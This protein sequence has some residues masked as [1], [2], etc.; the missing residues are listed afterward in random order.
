MGM[1]KSAV[2]N[3]VR[4][5]SIALASLVNEFVSFPKDNPG[6][7]CPGQAQLFSFGEYAQYHWSNR[8]HTWAYTS[9]S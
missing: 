2:C 9:T 6:Q 1:V 8:L 5:V 3:V 7:D 4:D